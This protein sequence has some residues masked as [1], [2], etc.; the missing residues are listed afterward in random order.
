MPL[1]FPLAYCDVDGLECLPDGN[2]KSNIVGFNSVTTIRKSDNVSWKVPVVSGPN[3]TKPFIDIKVAESNIPVGIEEVNDISLLS[4]L[5]FFIS[6][7][8]KNII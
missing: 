4:K 7:E 1:T 2:I 3:N 6:H 8:L 5:N